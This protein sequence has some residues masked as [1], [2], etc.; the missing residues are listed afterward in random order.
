MN[1]IDTGRLACDLRRGNAN[2][3]GILALLSPASPLGNFTIEYTS[4][5]IANPLTSSAIASTTPER[6][7][8]KNDRHRY[9]RLP[10]GRKHLVSI[11]QV[12]VWRIDPYSMNANE[13]LPC[14]QFGTGAS[15]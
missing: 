11:A 5:P 3:L 6:V 2:V 15:S 14:I 12:P 7:R 8:S 4:S 9:M 13:D 1:M 10:F